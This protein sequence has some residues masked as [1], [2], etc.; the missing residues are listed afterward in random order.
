[1]LSS[2]RDEPSLDP[3]E[4]DGRTEGVIAL[5]GCK[6]GEVPQRIEAY[7]FPGAR[8]A[9]ARYRDLFGHESFF[10]ELQDNLVYGDRRRNQG[11]LA[12]ARKLD[13]DIVATNNVHYHTRARHRLQDV[14]VAVRHYST[15]D[16]SE[17]VRRK[18]SEF[19]L[20]SPDEMAEL[21][22]DLPEALQNSVAISE[23]CSA[24]DLTRDLTYVFPDFE[25]PDGKT[26]DEFLEEVCFAA[27]REHYG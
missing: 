7:D 26:A 3:V 21:F 5:S 19:Y 17:H 15:L 2:P 11:L 8:A 27:A 1:L 10:I 24:F 18:N 13:L 22:A 6:Q 14:L 23:R 20:K 16:A 9:A 4:L 12:L 25:A